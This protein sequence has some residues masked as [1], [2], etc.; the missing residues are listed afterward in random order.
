MSGIVGGINLRSSGLV[1]I[2]SASDGQVFTGTGAGLPAGF[3]AAAGGGKVLQCV[4]THKLDSFNG[5]TSGWNDV[6]GMTVT[7]GAIADTASRVLVTLALNVYDYGANGM[8]KVV[9]GDGG[10]I[11][12]FIGAAAGSSQTRS[13]SG[14]VYRPH[15]NVGM[16]VSMQLM[17]LTASTDAR[18][19]KLQYNAAAGGSIWLNRTHTDSDAVSW[20]RSVSTIMATEIAGPRP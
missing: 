6:T 1:N 18:T 15:T 5:T 10:D 19:Y 14:S 4:H 16:H 12:N 2:G 20:G 3:E 17:D 7:T 13:S 9:D 8:L 11:T